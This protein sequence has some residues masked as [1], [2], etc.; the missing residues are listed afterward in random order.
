[1]DQ[2]PGTPEASDPVRPARDHA[3]LL[4]HGIRTQAEWQQRVVRVLEQDPAIR[5]IPTRYGFFD[6]LS[7]LLPVP[8]LRRKAADRI[9]RLIRVER[10][11]P[12]TRDISVVAHS[13]GTWIISH[14][15][16]SEPD[17]KFHRLILCGSVI[18]DTFEWAHYRHRI[19]SVSDQWRVINDC[20]SKDVWPVLAQS[21]TWGYG[22]SGRFGFGHPNVKDR[23]HSAGHSDFF[24]D[25]FVR[26][27]WRPYLSDG[28]VVDGLPDRPKA[29]WMLSVL[30]VAKLRYLIILALIAIVVG[31]LNPSN[32]PE[33]RFPREDA[34][35]R[36]L[37][38]RFT[39]PD[40]TGCL[41][42]P[43]GASLTVTPDRGKQ[44]AAEIAGC[45]ARLDWAQDWRQSSRASI[46]IRGA[47]VFERAEPAETLRLGDTLWKVGLK[48][49]A[50]APRL[51]IQL[52]DY[53]SSDGDSGRQLRQ[54]QEVIRNKIN[55]LA[56]SL[57]AKNP[58]CAYLSALQVSLAERPIASTPAATLDDWRSSNALLFLSGLVFR[59]PAGL[60]VRS[61]PFFG[62][63]IDVSSGGPRLSRLQLDLRIDP[64]EY[65]QTTDSHSLA[66]LYALAQDAH[67]LKQPPDVIL[68]F[69]A[70]AVSVSRGI[71]SEV[72][73]LDILKS[74]LRNMFGKIGIPAPVL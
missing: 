69:L 38:V 57:R 70:E 52:F 56:D 35:P 45:E 12:L 44:R 33:M 16:I 42:L 54:F 58:Q 39:A 68:V 73:G 55:M 30:T 34:T 26:T 10:D 50:S 22:S 3:I 29:P 32:G 28:T 72:P 41:T 37:T 53:A 5:V 43:P 64:R 71:D 13:F 7:F 9:A 36:S 48:P 66:V 61:Q 4:V 62:E 1:M 46:E 40:G 25:D 47:N 17:I 19:G 51:L 18:P 24:T 49:R 67:R 63:L 74:E 21:V 14:V 27:Y 11:S 6:L 59:E 2:D 20:G 8:W 23:F 60:M 31:T 65:S 15:L